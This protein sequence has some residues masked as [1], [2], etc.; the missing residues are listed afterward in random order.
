MLLVRRHERKPTVLFLEW[1]DP[2]F[3]AGHWIPGMLERG[4]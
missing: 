2:P 3:D 1:M 4:G